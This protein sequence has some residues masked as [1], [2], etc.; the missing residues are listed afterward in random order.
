MWLVYEV[1]EKHRIK[2]E[3]KNYYFSSKDTDNNFY[4]ER[5]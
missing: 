1:L 3:S 2:G 4:G 5:F